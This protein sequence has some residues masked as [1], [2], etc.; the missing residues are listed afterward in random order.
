MTLFISF[1]CPKET[2][3]RKR[4]PQIFFGFKIFRLPTHYN[5][6]PRILGVAQTAMLT[7]SHRFATSKIL[8]NFQKRFEG[9]ARLAAIWFENLGIK[10]EFKWPQRI[11][12]YSECFEAC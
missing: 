2:N 4:Q 9:F 7:F 3:Q 1:A 5:S 6:L 8:N 11:L 12:G 10:L